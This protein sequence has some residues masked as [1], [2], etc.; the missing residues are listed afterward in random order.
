[1]ES[2]LIL[3]LAILFVPSLVINIISWVLIDKWLYRKQRKFM[4]EVRELLKENS[5][6]D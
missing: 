5:T 2:E 6:Q 3:I 1:M 4:R